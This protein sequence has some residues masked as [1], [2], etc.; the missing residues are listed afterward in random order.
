MLLKKTKGFKPLLITIVFVYL[1]WLLGLPLWTLIQEAY[2][3]GWTKISQELFSLEVLR[4]FG[5]TLLLCL[6]AVVFNGIFGTA[7]ALVLVR[8]NFRGKSLIFG[9]LDLPFAISAVV[10]GYALILLF[11]HGGIL[12]GMAEALGI[13]LVF[14]VPGMVI[15]TLF[16]T[17]PFVVRELLPVLQELGE[18]QEQAAATL[19]ASPRQIFFSVTLPNIKWPL[20]YGLSLSFARALGEF[21]AVLVVGAGIAGFTET[22]TIFVFRAL[23]ERMYAGAYGASLLLILLSLILLISM[24]AV[25]KAKN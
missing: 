16:V 3:E 19:G 17:F 20:L 13:R 2:Q 6:S 8:Q 7:L 23:E 12:A 10:V 18:E 5:L 22:A 11:G 14:S 15:A 9:L 4:A 24:E 21:G 25:K 1:L